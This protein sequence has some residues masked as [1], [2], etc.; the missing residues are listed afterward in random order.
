MRDESYFRSFDGL[1][2]FLVKN[3][4]TY[5]RALVLIL[6]GLG[7][8]QG[9]YDYLAARLNARQ[10]NTWRFDHRGH[11]RSEGKRTHSENW[12]DISDDVHSVFK[13]ARAE[14]PD[15]PIFLLGLSMGG[16]AAACFATRFPG[17]AA[18][19]ILAGAPTRY[20]IQLL[21]PL[22]L[23]KP[24]D[25][26]LHLDLAEGDCS[27]PLVGESYAADPMVEFQFTAGLMNTMGEGFTYLK[28]N[29]DRFTDP[30]LILHGLN[31]GLASE[32]DSRELFSEIAAKDKSL[33]I[34][35]GLMHELFEEFD[36]D[37]VIDD[38]LYWLERQINKH[39]ASD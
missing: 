27:D 33:R 37:Q 9:R 30:V 7:E 18:G 11:G 25:E 28:A 8:H 12:T 2:L 1:K 32:K 23:D 6:H 22:P 3:K 21:G 35:A 24:N 36:K 39:K 17:K 34:Y 14:M 31:D 15:L 10:V 20:N 5:P 38:S 26:Y 4:V 13:L 29:S 16:Y 19:M